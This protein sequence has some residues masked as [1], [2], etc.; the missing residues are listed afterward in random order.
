MD[1]V[2]LQ[3]RDRTD[4]GSLADPSGMV[5]L[6]LGTRL[7]CLALHRPHSFDPSVCIPLDHKESNAITCLPLLA[8]GNNWIQRD[9]T[10]TDGRRALMRCSLLPLG[11]A[12]TPSLHWSHHLIAAIFLFFSCA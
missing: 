11:S 9:Q 5:G 10:G 3:W 2:W 1:G 6:A 12:A 7:Q 8:T 4:S